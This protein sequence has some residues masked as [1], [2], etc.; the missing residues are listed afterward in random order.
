M[1][2]SRPRKTIKTTTAAAP[3]GITASSR[4]TPRE[5]RSAS[6]TPANAM[7]A[8]SRANHSACDSAQIAI[9]TSVALAIKP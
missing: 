5:N 4:S 1:P 6:N 2:N 9:T 8:T 7:N 3:R